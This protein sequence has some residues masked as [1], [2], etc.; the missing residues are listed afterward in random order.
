MNRKLLLLNLLLIAAVAWAVVA[1]R[2]DWRAARARE[3]GTLNQSIRPLP[4]PRFSPLPLEQPVLPTGYA[5]IAQKDLFDRSRNPD[6]PIEPPPPPPPKP[7]MP[8]LPVFHGLMNIG[9]D[10]PTAIMSINATAPHKAVH[11]GEQIGQFKLVSVNSSEVVL[12][13]NGETV[14]KTPEELA[15]R[16]LVVA[17][18]ESAA[19]R[20][21]APVQAAAPPPPQATGPGEATNFGFR[22]CSVNDGHAE[23]DVVDG[24]RKVVHTS[25]FGKSCTYDPVK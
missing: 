10:G 3:A 16:Q 25:P 18:Q 12:E 4:P 19:A 11:P 8:A 17:Q 1:L 2:R 7:P 13:W 5:A 24:Y 15:N 23:G 21:E 20:T 22:M 6:V 14:R 9:P